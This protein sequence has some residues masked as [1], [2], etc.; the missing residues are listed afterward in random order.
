MSFIIDLSLLLLSGLA[1]YLLGKRREWSRHAK[2]VVGLAVVLI[3]VIFSVFST[4]ILFAA[5]SHS[6]PT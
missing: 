4:R 5:H 1:I 3:F 2:T 6:F